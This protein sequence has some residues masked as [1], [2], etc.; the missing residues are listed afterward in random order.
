MIYIVTWGRHQRRTVTDADDL[1]AV[2]D[3]IAA[4][5]VPVAVAVSPDGD[6]D[7]ADSPWDEPADTPP[8]VSLEIGIGHPER[9]FALW[10]GPDAAIAVAPSA[11]PWPVGTPPIRF[12]QGGDVVFA[13][14]D[15][16]PITPAAARDA[17]REFVR[18]GRRPACVG[19]GLA[20][21]D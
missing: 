7:R 21:W 15:R 3:E 5:G 17:A 20:A 11:G 10:S 18:T 12:D 19:W 6:P 13:G 2:L 4:A 14:A 1:D 9:A 8:G 16:A